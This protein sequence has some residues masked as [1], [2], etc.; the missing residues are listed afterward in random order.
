MQMEYVR[1]KEQLRALTSLRDNRSSFA[2]ALPG[3]ESR[4]LQARAQD[5]KLEHKLLRRV[6]ALQYKLG[7]EEPP[8]PG[9]SEYKQGLVAL[10]DEQLRKA[11]KDIER[12]V[13]VLG[14]ILQE[15][16]HLGEASRLTRSQ[17]NRAARRRKRIRQLVD[18]MKAWQ[19]LDLPASPTS[20]LLPAQWTEEG[21]L[22]IFKGTF[23]WKCGLD[24][25]VPALLAEQFRDA[26]A[27]VSN[28]AWHLVL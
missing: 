9:S 6:A 26:C 16:R 8:G 11:Q 7:W 15:R 22:D 27:E 13:A 4:Q 25:D 1:A 2:V 18:S 12:D 10:R 3:G 5:S 20:Q 24:T 17:H 21:I 14:T 19:Q 28:T 23:P